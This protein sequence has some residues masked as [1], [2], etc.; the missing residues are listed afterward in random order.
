MKRI[1]FSLCMIA[2]TALHAAADIV[3]EDVLRQ[4]RFDATKV[5]AIMGLPQSAWKSGMLNGSSVQYVINGEDVVAYNA[6][7]KVMWHLLVPISTEF[8]MSALAFK[9]GEDG[10]VHRELVLLEK[11]KQSI[12]QSVKHTNVD[13]KEE[14]ARVVA[15]SSPKTAEQTVR[16]T[17]QTAPVQVEQ[18]RENVSVQTSDEKPETVK[19]PKDPEPKEPEKKKEETAVAQVMRSHPVVAPSAKGVSSK[20]EKP[21]DLPEVS[22]VRDLMNQYSDVVA[23]ARR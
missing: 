1:I 17:V 8:P 20:Q 3:T 6:Q 22:S 10:V 13:S 14:V 5:T 9:M 18:K 12:V 19:K 23:E 11:G 7:S 16:E 2:L 15:E 4:V 21:G